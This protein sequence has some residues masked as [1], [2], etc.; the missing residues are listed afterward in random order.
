MDASKC[1]SLKD[2]LG[3]DQYGQAVPAEEFFDGNDDHASIGCNLSPHPGVGRFRDV[4]LGLLRRPDV[5]AVYM[6]ISELDPGPDGWPFTDTALVVGQISLEELQAAVA[7][8]QPDDV[9]AFESDRI[10][11][12]VSD[13]HRQ[14]PVLVVWWD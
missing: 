10:P 14:A 7:L 12:S 4:L 2:R 9:R 6:I 1:K 5:E 11:S 3:P 13:R 8:L